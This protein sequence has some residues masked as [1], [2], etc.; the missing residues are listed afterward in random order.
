MAIQFPIYLDNQASTPL[1][2]R[3]FKAMQP[4]MGEKY[5]NPHSEHTFGWMGR[6]EIDIAREDIARLIGAKPEEI[7]FTSGATEANNLAIKGIAETF[8]GKKDKIVTVKTEHKCVLESAKYVG[9]NGSTVTFLGVKKDGLLDP[10]KLREAVDDKTAFVS[11]MAVNNEI[12]VIQDVAEIGAICRE[13]GALF[14]TDAAQAFG[15]IPL[16]VEAMNIDLLSVSGHKIYGPVGVGALYARK[17]VQRLLT[18][19]MS[20]GGQEAHIR[21]GT[22]SPALCV[23]FG[24]AAAIAAEEMTAEAQRMKAMYGHFMEVLK[25]ASNRISVNGSEEARWFGNLNLTFEGVR[26]DL[27]VA[28]VK[29]IAVSTASACSTGDAGP[30]HVLSALGLKEEELEASIRI[31]FGRFTTREQADFAAHYILEVLDQLRG[32]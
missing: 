25:T 18:P 24:K 28:A 31:G 10:D 26:A 17:K 22:L 32:R 3:V 27:L 23:G 21:S 29:K 7:L 4:W 16:D 20:G 11:V 13:K 5:G 14:H 15:K 30:S 1:D 6:A 9:R 8:R 2:P 12:G 19:Q